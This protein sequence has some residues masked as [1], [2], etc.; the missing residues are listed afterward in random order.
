MLPFRK[1]DELALQFAEQLDQDTINSLATQTGFVKRKPQ[2]ITPLNFLLA[3]F[4]AVLTGSHS[5]SFFAQ[6]LGLLSQTLIS[7]QAVHKRIKPELVEFLERILEKMLFLNIQM[8]TAVHSFLKTHF[9][10]VFLQDSTSITLNPELADYFPGSKNQSGRPSSQLKIQAVYELLRECFYHFD[11]TSFTKNDQSASP[12]ILSIASKG[13]LIIRDLGYF[14]LST[15]SKLSAKGAFFCSRLQ[16]KV[17]IYHSDGLTRFDLSARLKKHSILD[18]HV[19]VGAKDK[20]PVRLVALPV[21]TS[22]AEERRRKA[23]HNRDR[24]LNPSK[25][26]LALLGWDI[27]ILNV[28]EEILDTKQIA[29]LYRLRWRIEIIF[30]TWKSHFHLTNVP[31]AC[32]TR[33][34]S[35]I[36]GMLIVLTTFHRYFAL[37]IKRQLGEDSKQLSLFKLSQFCNNHLWAFIVFQN[38]YEKI[39]T[40]IKYHCRYERRRKRRNHA[41]LVMALG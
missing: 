35:Y 30:K 27:F 40:Q 31:N 2:K 36:I 13:D 14:A 23:K 9:D 18:T 24:R 39:D 15:L 37:L 28:S 16:S 12:D 19:I 11:I 10:H 20:V 26:Y 41:Q 33:V 25:E 38:D 4:I 22:T 5:L 21:S 1:A 32:L 8:E 17:S 29:T 6:T 3:F 34:K 7:K